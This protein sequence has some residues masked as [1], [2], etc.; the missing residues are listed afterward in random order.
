MLALDV[1]KLYHSQIAPMGPSRL[2][3]SKPLIAAISGHAVAGGLELALLADMRVMEE[4][5][6]MGVFCRRYVMCGG[7]DTGGSASL[8]GWHRVCLRW[9]VDVDFAVLQLRMHH[10]LS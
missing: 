7:L 6:I 5:A 9:L 4:D 2:A 3:L 8:G 10:P 1:I